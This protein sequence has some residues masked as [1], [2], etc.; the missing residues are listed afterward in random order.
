MRQRRL[1]DLI[2]SQAA[3]ATGPGFRPH[4]Q[5]ADHRAQNIVEIMRK[6]S[7]EVADRLHLLRLLQPLFGLLAFRDVLA[8]VT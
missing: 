7:G 3:L 1:P 4:V 5:I 2:K 6:A 8:M